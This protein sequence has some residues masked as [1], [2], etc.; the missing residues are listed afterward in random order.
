LALA[1][2]IALTGSVWLRWA[3]LSGHAVAATRVTVAGAALD[4]SERLHID[5]TAMTVPA[6]C[7]TQHVPW[8]IDGYGDRYY[9]IQWTV[10][11]D[12]GHPWKWRHVTQQPGSRGDLVVLMCPRVAGAGTSTFT[13]SGALTAVTIEPP[14]AGTA[15]LSQAQ[16]SVTVRP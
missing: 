1:V 16:L 13:V 3:L 15:P 11:H 5:S 8:Q 10:T 2:A 6:G 9:Q 14:A 7:V 4:V 12:G